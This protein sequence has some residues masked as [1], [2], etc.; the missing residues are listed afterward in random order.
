[1]APLQDAAA[2]VPVVAR[3]V[4]TKKERD[5]RQTISCLCKVSKTGPVQSGGSVKEV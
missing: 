2:M 4:D 1:M 3:V 5:V